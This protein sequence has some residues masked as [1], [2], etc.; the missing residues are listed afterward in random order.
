M[1][2]C[3]EAAQLISSAVSILG[4]YFPKAAP[5]LYKPT[6]YN[7]PCCKWVRESRENFAWTVELCLALQLEKAFRDGKG[8]E[9]CSEV[10]RNAVF[11]YADLFPCVPKTPHVIAI[12]PIKYPNVTINPHNVVQTYRDYYKQGKLK[13]SKKG[14]ATWKRRGSPA[15]LF[16]EKVKQ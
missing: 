11:N 6:H 1:K 8:Y 7:H 3:L 14:E 10:A 2:M 12:N 4:G 5:L 16:E 13:F 15:W 9:K